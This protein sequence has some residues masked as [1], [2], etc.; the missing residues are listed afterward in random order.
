MK[1]LY[2]GRGTRVKLTDGRFLKIKDKT[3]IELTEKEFSDL[4]LT[5]N[6]S[7]YI[8]PEKTPEKTEKKSEKHTKGGK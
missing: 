6:Y 3:V 2:S 4:S 5:G 1:V 8:E 7:L